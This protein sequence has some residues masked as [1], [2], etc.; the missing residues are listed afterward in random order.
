MAFASAVPFDYLQYAPNF[1]GEDDVAGLVAPAAHSESRDQA[2]MPSMVNLFL[3]TDPEMAEKTVQAV[4]RTE[5]K[6][7]RERSDVPEAA[8]SETDTKPRAP[9]DIT[10]ISLT[11]E[12]STDGSDYSN[13]PVVNSAS[14][15]DAE[16]EK[17]KHMTPP[18][19]ET[20]N[21]ILTSEG[22]FDTEYKHE[23]PEKAAESRVADAA[24]GPVSDAAITSDILVTKDAIFEPKGPS[25]SYDSGPVTSGIDISKISLTN[26]TPEGDDA[27]PAASDNSAYS[28]VGNEGINSLPAALKENTWTKYP[29]AALIEEFMRGG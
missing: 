16:E 1:P 9:I 14:S 13:V 19:V 17:L 23:E 7:L 22:T 26:E 10:K 25:F 4:L 24:E 8:A 11:T 21:A 5:E 28:T 27:I 29:L 12:D 20:A 18:P 15:G 6:I 2:A 3:M